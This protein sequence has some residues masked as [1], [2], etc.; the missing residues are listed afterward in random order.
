MMGLFECSQ[1]RDFAIH[2][3]QNKVSA[4]S[5][6][7]RPYFKTVFLQPLT[8]IVFLRERLCV[9]IQTVICIVI[10]SYGISRVHISA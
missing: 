10:E 6:E 4:H 1:N 9:H 2:I 7:Q 5:R 8:S 3:V